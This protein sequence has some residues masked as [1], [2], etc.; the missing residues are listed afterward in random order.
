MIGTT[1]ILRRKETEIAMII[2]IKI[3]QNIHYFNIQEMNYKCFLP[4]NFMVENI[5]IFGI[6]NIEN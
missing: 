2:I 6:F 1:D 3:L 4:F 5:N